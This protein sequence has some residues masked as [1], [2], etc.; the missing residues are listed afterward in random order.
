MTG[1]RRRLL[2]HESKKTTTSQCHNHNHNRIVRLIGGTGA[3][4]FGSL[5]VW[6]SCHLWILRPDKDLVDR[7]AT[8][9]V[10]RV[11]MDD[12]TRWAVVG[13]L[14]CHQRGT[15]R[16]GP[17]CPLLSFQLEKTWGNKEKDAR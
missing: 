4:E 7:S 10:S 12:P 3:Q 1:P 9:L 16:K 15:K 17:R 13:V 11:D 8:A 6:E 14:M 5:G 2:S